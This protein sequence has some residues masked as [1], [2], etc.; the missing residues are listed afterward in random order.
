LIVT[1]HGSSLAD[2]SSRI[3]LLNRDLPTGSDGLGDVG[4]DR[5]AYVNV[6]GIW[7]IQRR[8][9]LQKSG[10]FVTLFAFNVDD[11]AEVVL[12]EGL[13]G[14]QDF[15]AVSITGVDKQKRLVV[16]CLEVR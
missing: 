5:R 3:L 13:E 4:I 12:V 14:L 15:D 2:P 9:R 1:P 8:H 10:E 6:L 11:A 7:H 16:H